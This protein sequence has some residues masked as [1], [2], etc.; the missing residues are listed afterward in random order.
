MNF[1]S[2]AYFTLSVKREKKQEISLHICCR[3]GM[4]RVILAF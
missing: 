1:P 2:P 4:W 3:L